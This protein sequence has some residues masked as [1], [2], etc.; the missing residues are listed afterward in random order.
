VKGKIVLCDDLGGWRE[1]FFA[2]AVGA[3]MQDGGAKD[4]AFSFPLPLSYLGKGEG[5]Y[6]TWTLQGINQRE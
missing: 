1:P 3:V 5:F 6:P 4:V 2:G